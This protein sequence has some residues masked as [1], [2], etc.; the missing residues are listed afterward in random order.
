MLA[1]FGAIRNAYWLSCGHLGEACARLG[2]CWGRCWGRFG[3]LGSRS[4]F[5]KLGQVYMHACS[6]GQ[7]N[8]SRGSRSTLWIEICICLSMLKTLWLKR[9]PDRAKMCQGGPQ[10]TPLL[11][12]NISQ[13][14]SQG[15]LRAMDRNPD[16]QEEKLDSGTQPF[17]DELYDSSGASI[18]IK[19]VHL[20][21]RF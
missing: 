12:I 6:H 13:D 19:C 21:A 20:H 4:R 11:T 3:D 17:V 8:H 10:E 9:W 18:L 7:I 5:F 2:T 15:P 16:A 14:G 1:S